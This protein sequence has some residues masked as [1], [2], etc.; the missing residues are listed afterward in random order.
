MK[1]MKKIIEKPSFLFIFN[2]KLE[3]KLKGYINFRKNQ[4]ISGG[5]VGDIV[6]GKKNQIIFEIKKFLPFPNLAENK[7]TS[8]IPPK[9]WFEILEEWRLFYTKESKF[10]GFL[11]THPKSSSKISQQD[12]IFANMLREKYGTILFII[13]SENKAIRS[14]MFN[15]KGRTIINGRSKYFSIKKNL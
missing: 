15:S 9:I 10:I 2:D 4:E 11:H 12:I 8:A 14:Y 6:G 3:L 5:L 7:K 1:T 13:V